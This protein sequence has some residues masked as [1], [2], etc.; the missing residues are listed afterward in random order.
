MT[1]R[2]EKESHHLFD[3]CQ[4]RVFLF[5]PHE[6]IKSIRSIKPTIA[7]LHRIFA[8]KFHCGLC[9]YTTSKSTVI[10]DLLDNSATFE[11]LKNDSPEND[12]STLPYPEGSVLRTDQTNKTSVRHKI[13]PREMSIILF[14]GQ[15]EF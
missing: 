14:P 13:D 7:M 4:H 12:W 3:I 6:N 8:R 2:K 10:N 15:G 9:S 5:T 11:D 1:N